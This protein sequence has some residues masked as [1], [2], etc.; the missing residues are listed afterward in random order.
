MRSET[1]RALSC[2]DCLRH[3]DS[4]THIIFR[5][6]KAGVECEFHLFPSVPHAFEY[7]APDAEGQFLAYDPFPRHYDDYD[8]VPE[9]FIDYM[10]TLGKCRD[11][12]WTLDAKQS[13]AFERIVTAELTTRMFIRF[14]ENNSVKYNQFPEMP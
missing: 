6:G 4:S 14:F 5:L 10:L 2:G 7:F 12:L 8:R 9:T 13:K 1:P 11:P 3:A